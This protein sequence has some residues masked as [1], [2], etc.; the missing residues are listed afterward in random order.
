MTD[1]FITHYGSETHR[2]QLPFV[3][4]L[5]KSPSGKSQELTII[6]RYEPSK[7]QRRGTRIDL[8]L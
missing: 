8:L 4:D 5:P 3:L 7:V 2:F 6:Y 1:Q